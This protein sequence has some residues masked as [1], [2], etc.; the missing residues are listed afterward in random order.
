[1]YV[2][3]CIDVIFLLKLMYNIYLQYLAKVISLYINLVFATII[4]LYL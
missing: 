1:M 4:F 2:Y 3:I